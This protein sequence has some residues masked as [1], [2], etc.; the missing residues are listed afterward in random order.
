MASYYFGFF[1]PNAEV[2]EIMR[3]IFEK[4]M[5]ITIKLLESSL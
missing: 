3:A 2:S 4:G 1:K 5:V